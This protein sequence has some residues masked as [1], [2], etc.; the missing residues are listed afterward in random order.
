MSTSS[1]LSRLPLVEGA[2]TGI[3]TWALGYMAVYLLIA[4]EIR[5]SPMHNIIEAFEGQPATY[6]MV[7]W[8]FYNAHFVNTVFH[9][10]PLFGSHSASYIGGEDGFSVVLYLIPV[11]VLL[12][13]GFGVAWYQQA[14]SP[15][16]GVAAG[17]TLLPGYL[18]LVIAGA[19]LFEVTIGGATGRPDLLPAIFLGGIV[20]PLLFAG[21]GGALGGVAR[22]TGD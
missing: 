21:I 6:E 19:F 12:I 9:D 20:Y 1:S 13:G 15:I 16:E 17:A 10:L 2:V 22:S 3:A 4:D 14:P 5:D 7:G 11:A 18:V 8:V